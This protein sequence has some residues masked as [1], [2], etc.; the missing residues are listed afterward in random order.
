[1]Y[2]AK[3]NDAVQRVVCL[4]LMLG[5]QHE[6][7]NFNLFKQEAELVFPF[8]SP[9][10]AQVFDY[11][12]DGN[13][14]YFV[15]EYIQGK[16]LREVIYKLKTTNKKI[17]ISFLLYVTLMSVKG[18]RYAYEFVPLMKKAEKKRESDKK[19]G[20]IH[21]DISSDNIMISYEGQTKVID[22]GVAKAK[23]TE[24][25][26]ALFVGKPS[27]MSP[28]YVKN[29]LLESCGLTEHED[30]GKIR[31]LDYRVDVYALGVMLWEIFANQ[32]ALSTSDMKDHRFFKEVI[33]DDL[34]ALS[35][36]VP[37]ID[38]RISGLVETM[39]KKDPRARLISYE[40]I[41]SKLEEILR[42][43]DPLYGSS[44]VAKIMSSLFKYDILIEGKS[45]I[46]LSALESNDLP[47]FEEEFD[48]LKSRSQK[49]DAFSFNESSMTASLKMTESSFVISRLG[50]S[51]MVSEITNYKNNS[52]NKKEE[53]DSL[54]VS[55]KP[56]K[57]SMAHVDTENGRS[58]FSIKKLIYM[59]SG[60]FVISA[61]I[62]LTGHY[63]QEP[64]EKAENKKL[65]QIGYLK[66][67]L[68][69]KNYRYSSNP[70]FWAKKQ[71]INQDKYREYKRSGVDVSE[72]IP[73]GTYITLEGYLPHRHWVLVNGVE[74]TPDIEGRV[75][76]PYGESFELAI[77]PKVEPRDF[78]YKRQILN[79]KI[80]KGPHRSIQL[81]T[82]QKRSENK[83]WR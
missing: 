35:G 71:F 80:S 38:P 21:R 42:D 73:V 74:Q 24:E 82:P 36:V 2:L 30:Y 25:D 43:T 56:K 44:N 23:E 70:A 17:P 41:E 5:Q 27:F 83:K 46:E 48:I 59:C 75:G 34:P 61:A 37:G 10:I 54:R 33:F 65:K 28:E 64:P 32:K 52:D 49:C 14:P 79:L 7:I 4:K 60:L 15:M 58:L 19:I 55:E 11:S 72:F 67:T 76:T 3:N 81:T 1:M 40:K 12:L 39:T 69:S 62:G 26:K 77:I 6:T 29:K 63:Y 57:Y 16:S 31:E 53:P 68:N 13:I 47:L 66:P 18:L 9:N 45:L 51:Q 78:Y 8:N 22:F 20:L 50:L